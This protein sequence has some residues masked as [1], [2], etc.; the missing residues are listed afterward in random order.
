[1]ATGMKDILLEDLTGLGICSGLLFGPKAPL[2]IK[3][4][5]PSEVEAFFE[6]FQGQTD[7]PSAI[8]VASVTL[9]RMAQWLKTLGKS[10]S[11][12]SPAASAA[13]SESSASPCG[14]G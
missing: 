4:N 6:A 5:L 3:K 1:M 12:P 9:S 7:I 2:N 8:E 10:P 11:D 14:A 13:G